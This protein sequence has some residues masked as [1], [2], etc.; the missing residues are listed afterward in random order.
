M[1]L[2]CVGFVCGAGL[3]VCCCTPCAAGDVAERVQDASYVVD[4]FCPIVTS[5]ASVPT[6]CCFW[7]LT[8]Y[9]VGG[10]A[11]RC[12][13]FFGARGAFPVADLGPSLLTASDC[14]AAL[15]CRV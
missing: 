7:G 14:V 2:P 8:R 12:V 4:C 3:Y 1:D 13:V 5:I 10:G 6:H 11:C 9:A 15:S